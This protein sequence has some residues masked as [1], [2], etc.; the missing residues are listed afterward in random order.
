MEFLDSYRAAYQ[1]SFHAQT[2]SIAHLYKLKKN[3]N[4]D[5][6]GCYKI[7]YS[8]S[9][10][11]NFHIGSNIYTCSPG[12]VFLVSPRDFHY[13]SDFSDSELHERFVLFV[14]PDYLKQCSSSQTDLS[15]CF[16]IAEDMQRHKLTLLPNEQKQFQYYLHKLSGNDSFAI[17]LLDKC[18]FIELL[19][20]LNQISQRQCPPIESDAFSQPRKHSSKIDSIKLYINQH[21]S[22]ELTTSV[23]A[24]H[25]FLNPTYLCRLFKETT[26]TTLHKYIIA[27]RITL[28]KGYLASGKNVTETCNICGFHDY[29]NFLKTFTKT[30]GISPKKYAQL[31]K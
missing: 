23:I 16:S 27:Q 28:A 17:D 12:D 24:S 10:T 8:L 4:I 25:F 9:G 18:S 20:F 11:K 31:S 7:F 22:E 19:V 15:S 6:L 5:T 2:F 13:F 30:V 29:S 21:I 3:M 14:Y 26:G 1:A